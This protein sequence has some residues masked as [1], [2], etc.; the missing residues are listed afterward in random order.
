MQTISISTAADPN[1]DRL[2]QAAF[3]DQSSTGKTL[4]E[5]LDA[6]AVKLGTLDINGDING[7]LVLQSCQPDQFF[8]ADQQQ[9][10]TELMAAWRTA[11][12]HGDAL[13]PEQQTELD[14]LIEAEL[15][16][17]AERARS[18][19]AEAAPIAQ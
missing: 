5:A 13:P 10:L 12:D 11:C 15:Y 18:V 4:G 9:R 6:L 14:A 1:G 16:A 8:T 17:T 2:Y 3:G 7:F 19:L